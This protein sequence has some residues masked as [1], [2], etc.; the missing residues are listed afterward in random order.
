MINYLCEWIENLSMY[1]VIITVLF[2]VLPSNSYEKYVRFF[3]GLILILLLSGPL[4][5]LFGK[6]QFQFQQ[7]QDAIRELEEIIGK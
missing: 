3:A 2:Q 6:E 5:K 1:L 7:Y 4:L